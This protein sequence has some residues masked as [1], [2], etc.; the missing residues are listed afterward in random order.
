MSFRYN[1]YWPKFERF[2]K[3]NNIPY[4]FL[5]IHGDNWIKESS[6]Y[7]RIVW[8]PLPYPS[9]LDEI[10]TKIAYIEKFLKIPCYPSAEQLWLYEDKIRQYYHLGSYNLP[11]IPTFISFDEQ[12]CIDK[13]ESFEY[14]LI[15]KSYVGSASVSVSKINNKAVARRYIFKAFSKG[16]DTGF[17]YW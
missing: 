17:S 8:R 5:N 7:D 16:L 11:I 15:S 9:S 12:E 1:S 2:A 6:N 10:R 4:A 13:L 14:P 3:V